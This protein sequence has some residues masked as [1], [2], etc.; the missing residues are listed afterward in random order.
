MSVTYE[1]TVPLV[2]T[3]EVEDDGVEVRSAR[4]ERGYPGF[5]SDA[6]EANGVWSEDDQEWV[7]DAGAVVTAAWQYTREA[8]AAHMLL[9]QRLEER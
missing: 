7:D 6:E 3:V 9:H 5:F 4:I 8:I 2:V 1:V